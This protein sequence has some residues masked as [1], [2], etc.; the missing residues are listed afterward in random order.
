M[1]LL[2]IDSSITGEDSVTRKLSA[3]IVQRLVKRHPDINIVRRDLVAEPLPYFSVGKE[4]SDAPLHRQLIGGVLEITDSCHRRPHVQLLHPGS[5]QSMAGLSRRGGGVT[6]KYAAQGAVGL[7]GGRRILLASSRGGIYAAGSPSAGREH[8]ESYLQSY[9][10]F[11]GVTEITIIRA[12]GVR[13]GPDNAQ[14]AIAGAFQQ[15]QT[16]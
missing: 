8:Q 11:L 10:Q 3:A 4:A 5:T 1:Q 14:K 9:F 6:F 13:M 12:E 15:V 2:H 16:V 7:A